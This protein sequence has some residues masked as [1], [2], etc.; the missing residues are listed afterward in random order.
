MRCGPLILAASALRAH[1]WW[2][3]YGVRTPR[4]RTGA[5][6][7]FRS[8]SRYVGTGDESSLVLAP[9]APT[10]EQR[11]RRFARRRRPP[12][13]AVLDNAR[14]SRRRRPESRIPAGAPSGAAALADPADAPSDRTLG[15]LRA[16]LADAR[17]A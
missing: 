6:N 12:H 15:N 5:M 1:T 11:C 14:R 9:S 13:G 3:M 17:E 7:Q 16:P 8:N 10:P 4:V 2:K